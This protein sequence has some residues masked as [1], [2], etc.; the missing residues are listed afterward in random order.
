M[1]AALGKGILLDS[2]TVIHYLRAGSNLFE[3]LSHFSNFFLPN[4]ALAEL[5]FGAYRSL[6]V[7]KNLFQIEKFLEHVALV[8][9]DGET[10]KTYGYIAANLAYIGKTIPQNDIWIAATALQ[11]DLPLATLDRHFEYVDKLEIISW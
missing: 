3:K 1:T 8:F 4:I 10:T 2:S 11:Y 5:Y 9:P 6:Q 7:Q